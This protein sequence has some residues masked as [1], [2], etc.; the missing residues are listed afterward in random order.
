MVARREFTPED[1]IR[2]AKEHWKLI[3]GL[4]ILGMFVGFALTAVLPKR[5]TSQTLVLVD[6]PAVSSTVVDAMPTDD[7]DQRLAAMQSQILSRT[8]LEPIIVQYGLYQNERKHRAME[9]LVTKLRSA[10]T[11]TPIHPMEETRSNS[12]PGF[13]VAV[14]FDDPQLAQSICSSITSM[15]LQQNLQLQTQR[16]EV[17]SEF[18]D[19]QLAD[20][21]A[22]L[23][24]QDEKL[25]AFKSRHIDSLPDQEQ[26]NLNLLME[27][28]SQLDATTQA[29]SRAQQ[30]KTFAESQLTQQLYAWQQSQTGQNPDTLEQQLAQLQTQLSAL[31][32]QYTDDYPDVIKTKSDIAAI[33]KKIADAGNDKK[34]T[35]AISSKPALEPPQIQQLRAQIHQY[36]ETIKERTAQQHEIQKQIE[37]YQTRVQSSP[38]VEQE[39][40]EL[41]RDYQTAL[42]FYNDLLKKHDDQSMAVDLQRRQEGEQFRVLDP[43]NLPDRPSFPDKRV[44]TAGGFGGGLALGIVLAL[45]LEL[46][47]TSLKNDREVEHYLQLPVLAMVPAIEPAATGTQSLGAYGPG[48]SSVKAQGRN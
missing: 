1:Y 47:D 7:M 27:L 29:L 4:A 22:A 6:K 37:T 25:A 46:K 26:T 19:K 2:M 34:D 45:F 16:A 36:D 35:P 39:Y 15:F 5:Y 12:L 10:I 8:R 14:T 28:S 44:F 38:S 20:A 48:R 40:K 41:T 33:K 3:A 32:A 23:D 30:D 31:Q 24:S 18:L 17:T 21:K 9:D 43:A 11:V 42:A 13:T